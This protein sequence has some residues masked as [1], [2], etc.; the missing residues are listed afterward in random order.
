MNFDKLDKKVT[1]FLNTKS[2]KKARS[3]LSICCVLFLFLFQLFLNTT[4]AMKDDDFRYSFSFATSEKIT[5]LSQIPESIIAHYQTIN[6]RIVNHVFVQFFL[7]LNNIIPNNIIWDVANS[8]VYILL[9]LLIYYHI[10]SSFK[11]FNIIRLFAIHFFLWFFVPAY[12]ESFYWLTGS[13]NYM[14]GTVCILIFLIPFT[15]YFANSKQVIPNKKFPNLILSLL[16]IPLGIIAGD[17]NE[18][19]A[20]ALI[21]IVILM[22]VRCKLEKRKVKLWMITG[23]IGTLAGFAILIFSPG[24]QSRLDSSGGILGITAIFKNLIIIFTN[25]FDYFGIPI[26]LLLIAVIILFTSNKK[27]F[28]KDFHEF[29]IY[30]LASG[31]ATFCMTLLSG[32]STRVWTGPMI[33]AVIAFGNLVKKIPSDNAFYKRVICAVM[34]IAVVC[35]GASYVKAYLDIKSTRF[36]FDE[37]EQIITQAIAENKQAAIVKPIYAYSKYDIFFAEW[38]DIQDSSNRWP[39]TDIARFYGIEKIINSESLEAYEYETNQ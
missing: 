23:F 25:F 15:K 18:N 29:F 36:L 32:F 17:T 8:L 26:L 13:C 14:W 20:L 9:L 19:T 3:I 10:H 21:S 1:V 6:G 7:M 27:M 22:L 34:S 37:R 12:G 38:A 4:T 16:Y 28:F 2:G 5:Q 39:N 31:I 33:F 30:L 35:F 11:Q 24:Q